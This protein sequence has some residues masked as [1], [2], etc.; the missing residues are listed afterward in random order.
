MFFR[1]DADITNPITSMYKIDLEVKEKNI[2]LEE[3]MTNNKNLATWFVTNCGSIKGAKN[4]F[5]L[6]RKLIDIGLDVDRRFKLKSIVIFG[7]QNFFIFLKE[8]I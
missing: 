2:S 1:R 6:V 3:L 4:I 5:S 7:K 8:D